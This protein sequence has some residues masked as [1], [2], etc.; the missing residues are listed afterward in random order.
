MVDFAIY[1]NMYRVNNLFAFR[2]S[3]HISNDPPNM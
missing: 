2:V 1:Y 3:D